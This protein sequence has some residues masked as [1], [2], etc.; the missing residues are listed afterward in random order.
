LKK[1]PASLIFLLWTGII[2]TI[3]Y[4]V[5]KP[6]LHFLS[7]LTKTIWTILVA[8]LLLFNA[9]VLGTKVLK[10]IK[11]QYLDAI[12]R[13]ILSLGIGLGGL[14]LLGLVFSAL[15]L[16]NASLLT[17]FQ[18]VLGALSI[19][20][21]TL[22]NLR[23]D[24][25]E[26]NTH[27][28]GFFS[29]LNPFTKLALMLPFLFSFLLTLTPPFES[30]DALSYHLALPERLLQLGGLRAIDI[31]A[32]WYPNI[33][34]Y[35]YLWSLA[36]AAERAAQ[37]LHLSWAVLAVLLLWRWTVKIRGIEIGRKTLLLIASLASLP[38]VS[39]W[40]YADMALVFYAVAALYALT[41]FKSTE[42]RSW[43]YLLGI[44]AGFAMSVK[45]TSFTVPLACGFLLLLNRPFNKAFRSAYQF[46]LIALFVALPWYVRNAII[47]HNPFY[48]FLFDGLF[49]D[50]FR[51]AWYSNADTGIGW[52]F[53]QILMI[54]LN[55]ILGHR[56]LS[57]VD[58]RIGPLFLVLLP[59]TLWIL[60][61]RPQR[62]S[63][64]SLRSGHAETW[65]LRSIGIFAAFSFLAWTL[66]VIN[67][68]DLWQ[69]RFFFP[70]LI[71]LAIPTALGWDYI[72]RLDSPKL[73]VSYLVNAIVMV[74][75]GLT[76]LD[77]GLFVLERNP[78]AV[79]FGAQSRERYIERVNPSYAELIQLMDELP[80][81]ANVYSLY[82]PRSYN[83]PRS[84]QPDLVL[85]NF[86]HDLHH[87]ETTDDIIQ[88]WNSEGYTHIIIYERGVDITFSSNLSEEDIARQ[89]ALNEIR[90]KLGLVSQTS[91][92]VYSLYKIP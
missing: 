56:E 9:Y 4:V 47:M 52:D 62:D 72:S 57:P 12:D 16:A 42:N 82:E 37:M 55:M 45:Y 71:P 20:S 91:D 13:L 81:D 86:A 35:A 74:V 2:I 5:P 79:A 40:A 51:S 32:F 67:S 38:L 76:M 64:L 33:T 68:A 53:I 10:F 21:G 26:F 3:F 61:N 25:K 30:F 50:S 8:A 92:G 69:V 78:L 84:T 31:P 14:G 83:L 39:S 90:D 54:P 73:R 77:T 65:S 19:S 27:W 66:G 88:R 87:Y 48:P 15:Q 75:I 80:A 22:K 29:Q 59:F 11:F 7:G 28:R 17:I 24:I 43:L 23:R 44:M 63:T 6:N 60:F 49:W 34:D 36:M 41:N 1:T 85:Y 46:S 18:F 70:A 89:F 58:G